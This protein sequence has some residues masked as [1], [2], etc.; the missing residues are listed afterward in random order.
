MQLVGLGATLY[1]EN[2]LR[3]WD[4]KIDKFLNLEILSTSF[5]G[6]IELS[7]HHLQE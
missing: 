4:S 3:L 7:H 5:D 6:A 1:L 2:V